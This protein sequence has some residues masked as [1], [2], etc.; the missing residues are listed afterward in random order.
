MTEHIVVGV[1]NTAGSRAAAAWALR[2]AEVKG[3][4]LEAVYVFLEDDYFD[5]GKAKA[6]LAGIVDSVKSECGS[7]IEPELTVVFGESAPHGLVHVS[8]TAD[9]LVVG[10]SGHVSLIDR[11][12]GSV[13]SACVHQ[14]HCPVVVVRTKE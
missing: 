13:S 5:E 9:L 8:S 4:S 11:M 10:A 14:A 7:R 3:A 6:K 2:E 1:D 12:L